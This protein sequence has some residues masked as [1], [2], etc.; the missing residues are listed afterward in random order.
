MIPRNAKAPTIPIPFHRMLKIVALVDEK[1]SQT[2]AFLDEITD[3]NFEIEVSDDYE[4]DV[5]EDA[6]VGAYIALVDG[7]RLERARKL[8]RSVRANGFNIPLWGLA[9]SHRISDMAVLGLTGEV[10]GYIY[11]GQQTPSFY[12][13]QVIGSLVNYGMSLLPPFF[14]GLMAYDSA[15]NIAFDCPGHQGGQFFR[16]SPAGQL[17]YKHFG[18]GIFRNDLC[19]ADVDLGDLLIHEGAAVRAQQNAARIFGADKTYFVLNGTSTSNKV[20]TG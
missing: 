6:D 15:A 10:D 12:A 5:S 19:N 13:K 2:K 20:V 18:E 17:F 9:D 8:G 1:N 14:G 7:D 4:R 11:L 3:S 16:K